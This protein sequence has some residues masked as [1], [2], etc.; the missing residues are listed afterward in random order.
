MRG[1][2]SDRKGCVWARAKRMPLTHWWWA[3]QGLDHPQCRRQIKTLWSFRVGL[4]RSAKQE[5]VRNK[6][7]D[8]GFDQYQTLGV[9]GGTPT[10]MKA[11]GSEVHRSQAEMSRHLALKGGNR[12][13]PFPNMGCKQMDG[14]R[15]QRKVFFVTRDFMSPCGIRSN[16][17][18]K[19]IIHQTKNQTVQPFQASRSWKKKNEL[20]LSSASIRAVERKVSGSIAKR[21][22][23]IIVIIQQYISYIMHKY[24]IGKLL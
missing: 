5:T 12:N 19:I 9:L 13:S 11:R 18:S 6:S 21:C 23:W 7:H 4:N 16:E 8:I 10:S 3:E 24:S 15:T 14:I 2:P 20:C 22:A 1:S 17:R